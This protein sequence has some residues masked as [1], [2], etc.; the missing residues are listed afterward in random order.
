[1]KRNSAFSLLELILALALS[2]VV[3][4]L[5]VT[6]LRLYILQLDRR[7]SD[8]E[9]QHVSRGVVR[10]IGDDLRAAI[11]YKAQDYSPL[12]DLIASQA[13]AG[14]TDLPETDLES[15]DA[16]ADLEASILDAVAA[17]ASDQEPESG[18]ADSEDGSDGELE[19]EEAE[20]EETGRPTFVGTCLLYTS[21]SPRD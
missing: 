19:D 18:D 17:G 14:L 4:G 21:P 9:Q 15:P 8:I 1:M 3:I 2:V 6:S 10:M 20:E 13:L 11:Q 5:I 16:A 7:Q 12:E